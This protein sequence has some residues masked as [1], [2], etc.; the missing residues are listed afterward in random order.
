MDSY[1]MKRFRYEKRRKEE[2]ENPY[3]VFNKKHIDSIGTMIDDILKKDHPA[4]GT[5]V[6]FNTGKCE[7]SFQYKDGDWY[8]SLNGTGYEQ[9]KNSH[10]VG[11]RIYYYE[12]N[13]R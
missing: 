9:M 10:D 3:M 8:F 4:N 11:R 7:Y 12:K 2:Q 6:K 13:R 1:E 5:V